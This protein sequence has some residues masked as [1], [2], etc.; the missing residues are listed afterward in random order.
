[1]DLHDLLKCFSMMH[2]NVNCVL[3]GN[4]L[5]KIYLK[6]TSFG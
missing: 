5:K 3:K 6:K 4:A 2:V 1:M